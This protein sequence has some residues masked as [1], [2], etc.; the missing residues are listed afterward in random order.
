MK[1]AVSAS[2]ISGLDVL[3]QLMVDMDMVLEP[4]PVPQFFGHHLPS[5]FGCSANS[6]RGGDFV[7]VTQPSAIHLLDRSDLSKPPF[8]FFFIRK[9]FRWRSGSSSGHI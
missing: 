8:G 7:D 3:H 5:I 9:Q 6:K 2:G 1:S 4:I